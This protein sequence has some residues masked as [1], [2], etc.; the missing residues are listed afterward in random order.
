[1]N[2]ISMIDRVKDLA[3]NGFFGWNNAKWFIREIRA[4]FSNEPSYFSSKRIERYFLYLSGI[5]S[6]NYYIF[7]HISTLTYSEIIALVGVE[8]GYAGFALITTQKEKA[9]GTKGKESGLQQ[10]DN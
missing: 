2:F 9:N 3:L 7:V 10:G 1:M 5:V 4:T 6:L 8:F